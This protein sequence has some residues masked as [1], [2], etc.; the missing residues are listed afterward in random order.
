VLE[1][2]HLEQVSIVKSPFFFSDAAKRPRVSRAA[3]GVHSARHKMTAR[4][5]RVESVGLGAYDYLPK[6]SDRGQDHQENPEDNAD[7]TKHIG[8]TTVNY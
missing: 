7:L 6:T 5:L 8:E 1:H 4:S 3:P 2:G